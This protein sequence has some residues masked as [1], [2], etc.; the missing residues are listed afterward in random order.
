MTE[1]DVKPVLRRCGLEMQ[2]NVAVGI[3]MTSIGD[4]TLSTLQ[5]CR[6]KS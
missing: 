1:E 5:L 2:I 6:V 3:F 4:L